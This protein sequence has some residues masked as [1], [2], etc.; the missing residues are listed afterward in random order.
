MTYDQYEN[1]S[2]DELAKFA[3]NEN[4]PEIERYAAHEML[5]AKLPNLNGGMFCGFQMI[6][7]KSILNAMTLD[8]SHM[9]FQERQ[10]VE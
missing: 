1:M 7:R 3:L 2:L 4:H 8:F 9:M 10:N 5:I 6:Q